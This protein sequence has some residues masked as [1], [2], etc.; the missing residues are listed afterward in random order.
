MGALV[1]QILSILPT[2]AE[3]QA[4]L[5]DDT[6]F[7]GDTRQAFS[8]LDQLLQR[9]WRVSFLSSQISH[10]GKVKV[11]AD[12]PEF[13]TLMERCA[14]FRKPFKV[15]KFQQWL[16]SSTDSAMSPKPRKR[17]FVQEGDVKTKWPKVQHHFRALVAEDNQI[18][19]QLLKMILSRL[20]CEVDL[21]E[22]GEKAYE[23]VKRGKYDIVLMDINMPK[24]NGG[25]SF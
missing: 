1:S 23:A 15:T 18:N 25:R 10:I 8:L 4:L 11:H 7:A 12:G 20:G 9:G 24:M 19:Q 21:V 2:G 6:I 5:A 16:A 14:F 13:A 22:D 17:S 3:R